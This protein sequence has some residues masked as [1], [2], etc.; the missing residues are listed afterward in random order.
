MTQAVKLPENSRLR[1]VIGIALIAKS[2]KSVSF[3]FCLWIIAVVL[4]G[5]AAGVAF[6]W[7][8]PRDGPRAALRVRNDFTRR[9][10]GWKPTSWKPDAS[11]ARSAFPVHPRRRRKHRLDGAKIFRRRFAGSTISDKIERHFLTLVETV[12]TRTLDRADVNEDVLRAIIR[13][14]ESEAF[15]GVKPLYGALCHRPFPLLQQKRAAQR[16]D[17]NN[18]EIWE[19]VVSLTP[20]A[21]RPSRSAELDN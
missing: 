7:L 21:P 20:K 4:L 2:G 5:A 15:L 17:R 12:Q 1:R 3:S 8:W 13:L 19:K 11:D 14:D 9:R 16:R 6:N 10:L 18:S